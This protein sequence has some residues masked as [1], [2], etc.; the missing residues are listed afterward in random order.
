MITK[1][2]LSMLLCVF[3]GGTATPISAKEPSSMKKRI[4]VFSFEDK[5]DHKVRWWNH[6]Q[7]I[8]EGMA[9]MLVTTMVQSGTFT[10][11]E[12]EQ[13]SAL[14]KEQ[15]LG[16][17]GAIT[18]Q[19]AASMGKMLGVD[20]AVFGSVTEFGY[21]EGGIGGRLPLKA[22]FGGRG[23]GI[24]IKTTSARVAVDVRLVNTTTGEIIA[25]ET[26]K[27]KKSK[28]GLKLSTAHFSFDNRNKFDES[29]V[30]KATREAIDGVMDKIS[31]NMRKLPWAG[32]VVKATGSS[33]IINAG[34][35]VELALGDVLYVYQKGEDLIDPDT[36]LN[37][38]SDETKIGSIKIIADMAGGK[39]S[40][41]EL[42]EGS[43][44]TRGDII[45]FK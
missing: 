31:Q 40:K 1:L 30:G 12:R 21:I 39:A 22:P 23:I 2:L 18:P 11:I 14:M 5:S 32:K 9:D 37:L 27:A 20:I 45:R 42:I 15:G 6:D 44:G 33:I 34:S 38:G 41:C 19:T 29:L 28:K 26:V 16:A 4:A 24:G 10:V 35:L 43:G 17:S 13:M 8:G 7:N 36:G 25:A 3:V